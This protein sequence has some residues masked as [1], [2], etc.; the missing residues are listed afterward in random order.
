MGVRV[1][2]GV[3]FG[4]SSNSADMI[5][6]NETTNVKKKIDEIDAKIGINEDHIARVKFVLQADNSLDIRLFKIDS[7]TGLE[8]GEYVQFTS[9]ATADVISHQLV[10]ADGTRET[11]LSGGLIKYLD[12][13]V[14]TDATYGIG[15]PASV[16][17]SG[18]KIVSIVPMI[19][20]RPVLHWYWDG[21]AY[22]VVIGTTTGGVPDAG[23]YSIRIFY[24]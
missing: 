22:R 1:K 15:T 11:L 3:F 12:T 8:T 18:G 19:N 17:P 10:S 14:T 20:N 6:Y 13:T 5:M 9:A 7:S 4:G 21:A 2:D 23:T 24:I 16:P